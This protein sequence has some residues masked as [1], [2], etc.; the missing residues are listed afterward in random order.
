MI[1]GM[2]PVRAMRKAADRAGLRLEDLDVIELNE[3]FASQSLA[4]VREWGLD[5]AARRPCVSAV[6]WARQW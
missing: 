6:A 1:V 3:A 5:P 4:V 2:G